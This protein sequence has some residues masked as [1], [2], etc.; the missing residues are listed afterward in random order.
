MPRL[1]PALP[2]STPIPELEEFLQRYPIDEEAYNYYLASPP[3]VQLQVLR[4]FR[5]SREGETNYSALFISFTKK[6]RAGIMQLPDLVSVRPPTPAIFPPPDQVVPHHPEVRAFFQRY[7]VDEE[8]AQYITSSPL[9][10]QLQV[11]NTFS[12][13]REGE[14]DYSA[15][16]I[17]FTRKCRSQHGGPMLAP[18]QVMPPNPGRLMFNN[19]VGPCSFPPFV[20][21]RHGGMSELDGFRFRYPMDDRAFLYLSESPPEARRRVLETFIPPRINDTDY[22]APVIAYAKACRNFVACGGGLNGTSANMVAPPELDVFCTRYPMDT[23]A[24]D[25]LRESPP[26]VIARVISE[27]HPK[28]EGDSDY[29]AAVVSYVTRCRREVLSLSGFAV[30]ALKRLRT[31]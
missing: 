26:E 19:G 25:Y 30:P 3:D 21:W 17:S 18:P 31:L 14:C 27:F 12:P 5:P 1:P 13:P 15:L 16:L 9:E 11:V 22:S 7:P 8:A 10:V 2:P 28:R 4:G 23:R 20:Q 6:C 24:M 29:S